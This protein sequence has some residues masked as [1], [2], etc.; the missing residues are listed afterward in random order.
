MN[1]VVV[2]TGLS[3]SGKTVALHALEDVGFFCMDN[4]PVLLLPKVV[5]L[6]QAGS[7]LQRLAVCV[8]ARDRENIGAAATQITLL[9]E[10]G[11]NVDVVFIDATDAAIMKRFSE[12]R[13]RH[14][15][16]E[17]GDVPRAVAD[18]R[19]MLA[20]LRDVADLTIDT[21]Q[22]NVHQLKHEI[23]QRL[24][25]PNER[26]LTVHI[27]SFGFKHGPIGHADLVFDV[28]FVP[29]PHFVPNLRG[30]TGLDGEIRDWLAEQPD[31]TAFEERLSGLLDFLLPRYAA[32]GRRYLTIAIGC[33]GGQHRSVALVEQLAERLKKG[34]WQVSTDHRDRPHWKVEPR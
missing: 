25:T 16:A 10:Q 32:E 6:A 1:A 33:T 11:M 28:R 7:G 23:Q 14:P 17:D 31:A 19:R 21:T 13:R 20:G 26:A 9:R 30:R 22:L 24:G 34:G 3:G 5:E 27:V 12:T 15:L 4:L 8:D 29:N 18:E 2:I